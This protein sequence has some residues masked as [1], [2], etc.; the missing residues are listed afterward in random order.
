MFYEMTH[1]N[2]VNIRARR[3]QR[4]RN[5]FYTR[6]MIFV[7]TQTFWLLFSQIQW[8]NQAGADWHL[9]ID[10][11]KLSRDYPNLQKLP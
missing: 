10:P 6:E 2:M 8:H 1:A 9:A 4:R 11:V 5:D 7:S 3:Y